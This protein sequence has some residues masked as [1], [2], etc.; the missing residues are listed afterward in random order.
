MELHG[1]ERTIASEG[2]E[3]AA[4]LGY[5]IAFAQAGLQALTLINGG[6]LVALFTFVGSAAAVKFDLTALWW[7]FA[8]FA[9][10]LVCNILAYLAAHLAQ[11]CYHVVAPYLA[12]NA[13]SYALADPGAADRVPLHDPIP[14][15]KR[16]AVAQM[17]AML[18]A[19]ISLGAFIGGCGFALSGVVAR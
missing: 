6:A 8:F 16:G 7:T 18:S 1:F 9:T 12:W 10:G 2:A 4:R 17:A 13:E 19:V 5:S 11:D 14:V 3:A 15:H